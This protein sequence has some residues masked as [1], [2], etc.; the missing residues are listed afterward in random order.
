MKIL[1]SVIAFAIIASMTLAKVS[2]ACVLGSTLFPQPENKEVK[3]GQDAKI[4]TNSSSA[5][6]YGI[7][8][9]PLKIAAGEVITK[10]QFEATI[11]KVVNLYKREIE[12]EYR[13]LVVE[14][15]WDNKQINAYVTI[16][17]NRK[18]SGGGNYTDPE[19]T[20]WYSMHIFGGL[21]THPLSTLDQLALVVCHETGHLFAGHPYVHANNKKTTVFSIEGQADYF[22]TSK[23]LKKLFEDEDNE[24]YLVGKIIP[25]SAQKSCFDTWGPSKDHAACIRIA[26]AGDTI[27]Q[28][29]HDVKSKSGSNPWMNGQK[30]MEKPD[31]AKRDPTIVTTMFERHPELQCRI[32]TYF[33]GALCTVSHDEL[34]ARDS[35]GKGSCKNGETGERPLCWFKPL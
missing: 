33:Q 17:G 18:W 28:M 8:Q 23:C 25:P 26:M 31:L 22:A 1:N 30:K 6:F 9:N 11:D 5:S 4:S 16:K 19:P 27:I 35:S 10:E 7:G 3:N 20:D 12:A 21:S 34:L 14:K 13:K 29:F 15:E 24:A 2:H 32:D